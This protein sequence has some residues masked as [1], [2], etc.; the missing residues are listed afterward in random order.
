MALSRKLL[1]IVIDGVPSAIILRSGK[2]SAILERTAPRAVLSAAQV[3][4]PTPLLAIQPP[5]PAPASG[6]GN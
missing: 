4:A 6:T 3:P 2:E 1:L 5:E